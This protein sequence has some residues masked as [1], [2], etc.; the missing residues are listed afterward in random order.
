MHTPNYSPAS[1]AAFTRV[2]RSSSWGAESLDAY[3]RRAEMQL[4]ASLWSAYPE[5]CTPR[6][7]TSN[8]KTKMINEG[9]TPGRCGTCDPS[10]AGDCDKFCYAIAHGDGVYPAARENH[11]INTIA[12]RRDAVAYYRHFFQLAAAAGNDLRV[13]ETGDFET[14]SQV[15]AFVAVAREFPTVR[16]IGYSKREALLPEIAAANKL[17]NV[18]LHYSLAC[19]HKGEAVARAAGVPCTCVTFDPAACGCPFQVRKLNAFRKAYDAAVT[20]SDSDRPAFTAATA[21]A[22]DAAAGWSCQDC[23]RRG[24]GCFGARDVAFLAH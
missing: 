15:R 21:A 9:T 13:N 23:A 11:V 10:C 14:A 17:P 19:C 2:F 4:T 5:L 1:L 12:R 20:A 6:A 16:V 22:R 3:N 8:R 18:Q 7:G 24:C